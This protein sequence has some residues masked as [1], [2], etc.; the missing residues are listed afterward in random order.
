MGNYCGGGYQ[1]LINHLDYIEGMGFDAIWIS[2]FVDNYDGDYHG[3]AA[4]NIY[5]LNSHF[6]TKEQFVEFVS[7]CHKRNIYV[8]LDVVANHMGNLD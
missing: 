2:P 5:E 6:G 3:Y 8:M 1:G 7:A 4:R